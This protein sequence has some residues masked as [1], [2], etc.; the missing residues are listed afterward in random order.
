MMTMITKPDAHRR[1]R[2]IID[3]LVDRALDGRTLA[4]P[5][6]YRREVLAQKRT[7]HHQT[8]LE[9][10]AAE[11]EL[12]DQAVADLL[13]PPAAPAV[14]RHEP[15]NPS[16]AITEW[17]GPERDPADGELLDHIDAVRPKANA[18]RAALR[19]ARKPPM[20]PPPISTR[21]AIR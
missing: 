8:I 12:D 21:G 6:G 17:T 13:E 5:V 20:G 4:N 14:D 3:L 2:T 18:A 15:P 9:I 10:L 7:Q 16:S 11:P 1:A 19:A